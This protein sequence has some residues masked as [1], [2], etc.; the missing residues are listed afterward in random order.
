MKVSHAHVLGWQLRQQGLS[1][2]DGGVGRG[3]RG[4]AG[5]RTAVSRAGGWVSPVAEGAYGP[6]AGGVAVEGV[7]SAGQGDCQTLVQDSEA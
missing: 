4:A 6:T 3:A 5:R 2:A 1:A 7:V